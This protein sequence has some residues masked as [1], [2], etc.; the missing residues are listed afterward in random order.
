M[1]AQSPRAL[2]RQK[3]LDLYH[4]QTELLGRKPNDNEFFPLDVKRLTQL[5]L[6]EWK[7]IEVHDLHH[8]DV[9]APIA[10]RADFASKIIHLDSVSNPRGNYTAAHE[11]GHVFLDHGGCRLR[12]DFGPRSILRPDELE[13]PT[14]EEKKQ[15]KEANVFAAELLMPERTVQREFRRR[16]EADRLWTRSTQA[17][18]ILRTI[19]STAG[20]AA[21]QLA[22]SRYP[23]DALPLTEFFGVSVSAMR[24]RLLELSLVH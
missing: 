24:I 22:V 8:Q 18:L 3:L 17:Q 19:Y 15:E 12:R 10:G 2:A 5:L 7:I 6:P 20:D 23:G 14:P 11:L 4:K 21:E 13:P 16:F 1:I 9:S